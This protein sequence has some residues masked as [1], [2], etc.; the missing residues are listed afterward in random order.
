MRKKYRIRRFDGGITPDELAERVAS[1]IQYLKVEKLKY[2]QRIKKV[3]ERG[4]KSHQ[5]P[6]TK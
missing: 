5:A 2:E 3:E 1:V 6:A 4:E